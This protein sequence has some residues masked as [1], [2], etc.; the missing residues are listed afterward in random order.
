MHEILLLH[1][2]YL[3]SFIELTNGLEI[4]IPKKQVQQAQQTQQAQAGTSRH[5]GN[6]TVPAKMM[7]SLLYWLAFLLFLT[8]S[9]KG[10][11]GRLFPV[12]ELS[13]DG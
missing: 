10:G 9:C 8:L 2:F 12:Q 4:G 5:I 1:V 6:S 3:I 13:T 11:K 7:S